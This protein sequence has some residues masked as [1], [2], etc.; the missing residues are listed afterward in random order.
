MTKLD[1]TGTNLLYSTYL[2][3]SVNDF[4]RGIALDSDGNAMT[5]G[6]GDW[7]A[8]SEPVALGSEGLELVL[9]PAGP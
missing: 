9:E 5:E 8:V 1:P 4:G 2:G 6:A 7:R 3:G